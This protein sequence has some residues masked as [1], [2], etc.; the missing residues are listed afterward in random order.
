MTDNTTKAGS[1]ARDA[2]QRL[3]GIFLEVPGTQLSAL[4]ASR[5]AG[6]DPDLCGKILHD[7]EEARF[8]GRGRRGLF[9]HRS[10]DSPAP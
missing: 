10:P 8:L 6:L 4:Q 1:D 3:K 9:V 2:V 7:L 5:L